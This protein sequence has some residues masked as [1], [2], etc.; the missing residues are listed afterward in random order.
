MISKMNPIVTAID[1]SKA[2]MITFTMFTRP[3]APMKSNDLSVDHVERGSSED[4]RQQDVTA[5]ATMLARKL[6]M[7][8]SIA[9]ALGPNGEPPSPET[10]PARMLTMTDTTM[11]IRTAMRIGPTL[12]LNLF[13]P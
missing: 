9:L 1:T 12:S 4:C 11:K 10:T 6:P 13:H 7:L 5:V 8:N 3:N 2:A